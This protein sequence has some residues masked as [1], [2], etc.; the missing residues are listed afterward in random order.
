[1][2]YNKLITIIKQ[3]QHN[4]HKRKEHKNT[5]IRGS[6]WNSWTFSLTYTSQIK[7]DLLQINGI[8]ISWFIV[9]HIHLLVQHSLGLVKRS[10]LGSVR[11]KWTFNIVL[12]LN[13]IRL[14]RWTNVR[15][16]Y[17][18]VSNIKLWFSPWTPI[19]RWSS[20][21]SNCL[22]TSSDKLYWN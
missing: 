19:L 6:I 1:M 16:S 4:Y 12:L 10:M 20:E 2:K 14:N 11:K 3:E 21:S 8:I 13:V 7:V 9:F 17:E 22:K 18:K 5:T 15:C